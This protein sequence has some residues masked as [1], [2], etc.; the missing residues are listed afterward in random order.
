MPK[1]YE[2]VF[3]TKVFIMV[4]M[5]TTMT[6]K[7]D[8]NLKKR[9]QDT[10]KELGLPLST[11]INAYLKEMTKTGRVSFSTKKAIKRGLDLSSA[12]GRELSIMSEPALR[13]AWDSPEEDEAWKH[14]Q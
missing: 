4:Y 1:T 7:I 6:F 8:K 11:I 14:L 10:A 2:F 3:N 9:A 5:K 13:K 12:P